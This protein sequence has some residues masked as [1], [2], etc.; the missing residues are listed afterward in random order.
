MA[1]ISALIFILISECAFADSTKSLFSG[2]QDYLIL[3]TVKDVGEDLITVTVDNTVGS[4][5]PSLSGTD[6][7]VVKFTYSYC[8]EHTTSDFNQPKIGDNIFAS[9]NLTGSKYEIQSGAYKVDS[10]EIKNCSTIVYQD[11]NNEQCLEDAVKI[12]YF[13]RSNGKITQFTTENDGKIYALSEDGKTLIYP[14]PDNQC[15]KFVDD[16]GKIADIFEEDVMPIVSPPAAEAPH[17]DNR[18]II[19]LGVM[20]GGGALGFLAFYL[21]YARKRI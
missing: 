8:T 7:S 11:M 1:V 3:G 15:I 17:N 9:V 13:I 18:W 2:K 20:L 12:A 21:F 14:L 4:S 10:S 5:V 19:A 6:I 16:S